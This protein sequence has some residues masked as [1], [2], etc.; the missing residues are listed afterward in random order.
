MDGYGQYFFAVIGLMLPL[1]AALWEF[2]F[3]GRKRLGYRVQMDTTAQDAA[4]LPY[5]G[6]LQQ[7]QE[8]DG[9]QLRDPSFVLL[10][11]ENSGW[12][13]IVTGDYQAPDGDLHAGIKVKFTGRHV[14]GMAVTEMSHEALAGF[15]VG[16]GPTPGT[17]HGLSVHRD[18]ID[19]PKVKLNR[20]DHYKVLAILER[21]RDFTDSE[22]PEPKI[23]ARIV[24]GVGRGRIRRTEYYPFASKPVRWVL[25]LLVLVSVGQSVLTFTRHD[26]VA[27]PLDCASGTLTLSGS[28]AFA[29]VVKD[30]AEQYTKSCPDA[31]IPITG[32]TFQSSVSGLADLDEAGLKA[33]LTG[34]QGLGDRLTFS[35][36]PKGDRRPQLLPRPVALLLFTLV[37]NKDAGVQDLTLDQV[38][39]IYAGKITNWSQVNGNDVPIHLVSRHPG[40]GTRTTFEDKVLKGEKSLVV[41]VDDCADL[42]PATYGRCETDST[43]ALLDTVGA[44]RGALGYSEAGDAAT[45][46]NVQQVRIDGYQATLAGADEGAYPYWQTEYAYTY[47]E[48]PA[49][50]LAA[51]FLRYL[52]NEVGKDVIRAHGDRPCSELA[53]PLVCSPVETGPEPVSS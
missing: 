19:L 29:P 3:A 46:T 17:P 15:F 26:A 1:V 33:K 5:A 27:A 44:T 49:D 40:S 23:I 25:A 12:A 47:G 32:D 51:G 50:S 2:V 38:R 41:T 14:V 6:V 22:F 10:R 53:K 28:T 24:G 8:A 30:A 39:R 43:S 37:V 35:D 20:G 36:G 18:V 45:S 48:P 7:L 52:A 21:A 9:R 31:R 42:D 4:S 16:T 13:P 11:F 34:S